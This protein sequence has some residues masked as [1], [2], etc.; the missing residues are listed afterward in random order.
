MHQMT[1]FENSKYSFHV[2]NQYRI[3]VYFNM[4]KSPPLETKIVRKSG[5]SQNSPNN[6]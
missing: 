5:K 3:L 6:A 4:Q 2:W 1:Y